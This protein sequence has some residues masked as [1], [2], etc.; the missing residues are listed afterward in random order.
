[1]SHNL[2]LSGGVDSA[3]C[4][5]LLTEAGHKPFCRFIQCWDQGDYCHSDEDYKDALKLAT[6]LGLKLSHLNLIDEYKSEVFDSFIRDYKKGLTPNQDVLC[7]SK[8]KFN[9]AL[10]KLKSDDSIIATGHYSDKLLVP[11]SIRNSVR[12]DVN[13]LLKI[14]KDTNKDQTYFLA[15]IFDMPILDRVEFPLANLLK[16]EVKHI[17][18]KHKL[19]IAEKDESQGICFVGDIEMRKF[20]SIYI[21]KCPGN[22]INAKGDVV[23]Q[24]EGLFNYTIGQRKGIPIRKYS[25]DAIYVTDK[26]SKTNELVVGKKSDCMKQTVK[27]LD[28]KHIF[29]NIS[30]LDELI[31]QGVSLRIRSLGELVDIEKYTFSTKTGFLAQLK[32]PIFAP[33]PGQYAVLYWNNCII[34]RGIIS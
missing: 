13:Y 17:A 21:S 30:D 32:Q 2:L 22:I 19:K 3:V 27:M 6:S 12:N 7:N 14:P 18:K 26:C 8:I 11:D 33:A 5:I 24:H 28:F 10:K 25:P 4:A 34:A 9:L 31:K 16:S 29:N 15:D 23:G 20:L 1:M